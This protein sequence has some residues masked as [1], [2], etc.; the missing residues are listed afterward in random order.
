MYIITFTANIYN[1]VKPN[2]KYHTYHTVELN[3]YETAPCY[4]QLNQNL[5]SACLFIFVF[6]PVLSWFEHENYFEDWSKTIFCSKQVRTGKNTEINKQS[7]VKFW[8]IW[9]K[10]G[11]DSYSFSCKENHGMQGKASKFLLGFP[12]WLDIKEVFW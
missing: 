3:K 8:L 10:C 2:G 4:L 11:L 7:D 12:A 1:A 6:A 9:R 5:T